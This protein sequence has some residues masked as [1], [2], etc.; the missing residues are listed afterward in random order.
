[1]SSAAATVLKCPLCSDFSAPD[2]KLLLPHIRLVHSTR[3]G[4]SLQCNIESC[5]RIFTNMKTYTNHIYG[6][7]QSLPRAARE[8]RGQTSILGMDEEETEDMECEQEIQSDNLT[9]GEDKVVIANWL[10]KTKEC[11]KLTQAT[12]DAI[13][14]G[15]TDLNQLIL[16]RVGKAVTTAL[17]ENGINPT[18]CPQL[19]QIFDINGEYGRP[20]RGLET[21]HLQMKYFKEKLGYVVKIIV[22][23]V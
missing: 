3:P 1:M 13:I 10:L 17:K 11:S 12:M 6:D 2:F 4:F 5:T 15:V 23:V 20:F 19:L 21:S 22:C 8:Y 7:H 9:S 14:E 18:S 16:T